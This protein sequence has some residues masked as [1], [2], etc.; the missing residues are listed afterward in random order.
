MYPLKLVT[1]GFFRTGWYK[2]LLKRNLPES[3][4]AMDRTIL[5]R[6]VYFENIY[7]SLPLFVLQVIHLHLYQHR[8]AFT[9]AKILLSAFFTLRGIIYYAFWIKH[10]NLSWEELYPDGGR[11][12]Q[13]YVLK[14]MKQPAPIDDEKQITPN[15][16]GVKMKK[17]KA[18]PN[19]A[20]EL[21]KLINTPLEK[22]EIS[23]KTYSF[24][25]RSFK[26]ID[27]E[28]TAPGEAEIP[29]E[30]GEV[31]IDRKRK[32]IAIIS[33]HVPT[34]EEAQHAKDLKKKVEKAYGDQGFD[35]I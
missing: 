13:K 31:A 22:L 20:I 10:Q 5:F 33:V 11:M 17:L 6:T 24:P 12:N 35:A 27:I 18:N 2:Y 9:M 28:D 30:E 29:H 4:E 34:P 32:Q 14:A 3:E 21:R 25:P 26:V 7:L 19:V 15:L 23:K 16:S 1:V 8:N